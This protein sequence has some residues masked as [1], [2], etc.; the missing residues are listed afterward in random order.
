[1]SG[2]DQLFGLDQAPGLGQ[3]TMDE[4]PQGI[5]PQFQDNAGELSS[6]ADF[7][8]KQTADSEKPP[9][10]PE[11][12]IKDGVISLKGIPMETAQQIYGGFQQHQQT[13]AAFN[14][15]ALRL[16]AQEDKI[17]AN[18]LLSVLSAVAAGAAQDPRMPPIVRALG[19]ANASLNPSPDALAQRR[20]GILQTLAQLESHG[21]D[22]QSREAALQETKRYHNA[23]IADRNLDN[24]RLRETAKARVEGAKED[25]E[26]KQEGLDERTFRGTV[27]SVQSF[28]AGM[29]PDDLGK[30]VHG[31]EDM[32]EAQ[33]S[34]VYASYS[35][36]K[37]KEATA[38]GD[39]QERLRQGAARVG[40]GAARVKM[41]ETKETKGPKV[42]D[43]A[44]ALASLEAAKQGAIA[45]AE[46]D[47]ANG[48]P[49]AAMAMM[50]KAKV[51]AGEIERLKNGIAPATPTFAH[52]AIV[53]VTRK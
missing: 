19:Y 47:K 40:Q 50:K 39:R 48:R 41:A 28:K 26:R 2:F 5:S 9:V 29:S 43:P 45:Q 37:A 30:A 24:A 6:F 11:F 51:F 44:K 31:W 13:Q 34:E 7:F 46:R 8:G 38:E 42:T 49:D 18:P 1:V 4:Q 23:L 36:A 27:K 32:S 22:A 12:T 21:N 52:P 15:E 53:G 16:K 20:M 25:R 10:S 3:G 35:G 17:R 14:A 33:R